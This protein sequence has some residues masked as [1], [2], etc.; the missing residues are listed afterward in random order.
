MEI[1]SATLLLN[2][3][4]I[5]DYLKLLFWS[6]LTLVLFLIKDDLQGS[7]PRPL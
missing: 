4:L 3:T 1:N 5:F 7:V 2:T 6:L